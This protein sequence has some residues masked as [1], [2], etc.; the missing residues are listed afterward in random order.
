MIVPG[1][2]ASPRR[3]EDFEFPTGAGR[4]GSDLTLIAWRTRP[5]SAP[6]TLTR[7]SAG[8]TRPRRWRCRACSSC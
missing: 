6:R 7:R 2:G 4:Y 8:S 5:L 3:R 1:I